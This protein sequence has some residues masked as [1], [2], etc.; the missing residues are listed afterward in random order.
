MEKYKNI[1]IT[2]TLIPLWAKAV[3]SVERD[4]ILMDRQAYPMLKKLGYDLNLYD[5]RKQNP[6]Q[7][8]C[9]LRAKWMD[10]ETLSFIAQHGRCQ[11]IQLGAG[12]DDRFRRIGMPESVVHWYDLDLPEVAAMRKEVIPEVDR[13]KILSMNMF[14]IE[15]MQLMKANQLPT[16]VI[17]EGVLMYIPEEDIKQLI[18]KIST[19]LGPVILL[20]DSVPQIAVGKAKYHDS[21]KKYN[22]KVEY[23][24]GIK[25]TATITQLSPKVVLHK[26]IYMSDLPKAYKFIWFLRWIWKIP[27]F[28]RNTNQLL[29]KIDIK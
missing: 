8:G 21:V 29:V 11:V 1:L 16:L 26:F 12:I 19:H 15:W 5:K 18:E 7:V 4:P 13:N 24:W 23:V 22:D 2:T 20:C 27:Y 9:C 25:N 17:I 10:D 3:E 28:Y 6:S 14:D